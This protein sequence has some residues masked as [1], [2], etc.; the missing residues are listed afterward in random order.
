VP[1]SHGAGNVMPLLGLSL[2]VVL[3]TVLV[4]ATGPLL[5]RHYGVAFEL[6]PATRRFRRLSRFG[7]LAMFLAVA[8]WFVLAAAIGANE[9]LLLH[10]S[11]APWMVLLYVLGTIALIGVVAIVAHAARTL[12]SA[13]RGRWVKFGEV[14]LALSALYLGWF[15]LAFGLVSFNTHF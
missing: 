11:A 15:V 5:R 12:A 8:G 6:P 10:G 1:A 4:W 2:F 7:G 13:R 3:A 9:K 14:V